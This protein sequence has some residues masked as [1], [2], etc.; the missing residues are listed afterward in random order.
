MQQTS[1]RPD[2]DTFIWHFSQ[3]IN[4]LFG[5][6]CTFGWE[7]LDCSANDFVPIE[8]QW[9]KFNS[10][11]DGKM[12]TVDSGG[13]SS[14]LSIILDAQTYE[15]SYGRFSEGFKVVIHK[16]GEYIDQWEG[17]NVGPGQHAVIALSEK[18]VGYDFNYLPRFSELCTYYVIMLSLCYML[19][20]CVPI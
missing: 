19:C 17:I 12:K 2:L 9:G 8:T 15:Y 3:D 6:M 14:G 7:E 4:A 13:I 18:R 16:Q 1:H 11:T 20:T 5:P 10:E